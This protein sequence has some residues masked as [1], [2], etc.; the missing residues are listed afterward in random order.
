VVGGAPDGH[1]AYFTAPVNSDN[2]KAGGNSEAGPQL[3]GGSLM[4]LELALETVENANSRMPSP[5]QSDFFMVFPPHLNRAGLW[6]IEA[7]PGSKF[8]SVSTT[9]LV[10]V[11]LTQR[12]Q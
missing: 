3:G 8:V 10:A 7:M 4:G 9:K 1:C 5:E 6:L 12:H 11:F 2:Q